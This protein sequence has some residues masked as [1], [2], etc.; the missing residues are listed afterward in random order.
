MPH[1]PSYSTHPHLYSLQHA[2]FSQELKDYLDA[3]GLEKIR[4]LEHVVTLLFYVLG[5]FMDKDGL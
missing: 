5:M 2:E 1:K 4:Q 3:S